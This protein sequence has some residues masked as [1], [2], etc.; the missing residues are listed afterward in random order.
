MSAAES[1][2]QAADETKVNDA[3]SKDQLVPPEEVPLSKKALKRKARSEHFEA[4]KLLKRAAYKERK[5]ERKRQAREEAEGEGQKEEQEEE[6]EPL[7]EER[8]A[9]LRLKRKQRN[10][11]RIKE[12]EDKARKNYSVI[13]DCKWDELHNERNLKSLAQ[14][15]MQSYGYNKVSEKPT[16][17]YVTGVSAQLKEHLDK[18]NTQAWMGAT[19]VQDDDYLGMPQF[20]VSSSSSSSSSGGEKKKQLVYLSSDA[21]EILEELDENCVYI[22]GGIVDRNKHK[23]IAHRKAERQNIRTAKLPITEHL[24]LHA[25]H[26]L[27][28]NHVFQLLLERSVAPDWPTALNT[29]IPQRKTQPPKKKRKK[30]KAGDDEEMGVKLTPGRGIEGEGEGEGEGEEEKED[31]AADDQT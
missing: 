6:P 23:G 15:I 16:H 17:M 2:S 14:Q 22:I 3:V 10:D 1:S 28:V 30:R 26:V 9:E 20:E 19:F 18:L 13:I 7:S 12:F 5:K 11:E 21:D 8:R 31:V 4:T 27:T 29:V 24:K 25:T